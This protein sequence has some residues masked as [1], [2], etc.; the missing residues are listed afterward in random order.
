MPVSL[1]T[2][3]DSI[4]ILMNIVFAHFMDQETEARITYIPCRSPIKKLSP[5]LFPVQHIVFC[6]TPQ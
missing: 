2:S 3:A 5:V 6:G 1:L 4:P